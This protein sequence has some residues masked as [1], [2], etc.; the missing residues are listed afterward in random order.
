MRS[1]WASLDGNLSGFI[2]LD[3][4]DLASYRILQE[5]RE[6]C[7]N[8]K[9]SIELAFTLDMD[10]TG[11]QKVTYAEMDSY[12]QEI[13][14]KSNTKALCRF[15]DLDQKGFVTLGDLDFL[16][17]WEGERFP[18]GG[19]NSKFLKLPVWLHNM[20]SRARSTPRAKPTFQQVMPNS[21]VQ[22]RA[23]VSAMR[24]TYPRAG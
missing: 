22:Q 11:A 23:D 14:V 18:K 2:T 9:G 5:F 10:C 3:K 16:R 19:P 8:D 21:T 1:L 24:W 20:S 4:W 13:G 15:L 17:C 6:K 7:Q 12:C